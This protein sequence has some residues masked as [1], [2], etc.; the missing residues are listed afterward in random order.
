MP[1]DD[2]GLRPAARP[3]GPRSPHAASGCPAPQGWGGRIVA[4]AL[5]APPWTYAVLTF[6]GLTAALVLAALRA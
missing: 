4:F 3:A 6:V 2:S 5:H 1:N